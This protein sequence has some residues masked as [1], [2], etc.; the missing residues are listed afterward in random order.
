MYTIKQAAARTGIPIPLLRAWQSRY[1]IVSPTRTAAGY[2]LYDDAALDRLRSMR[3]LVDEGWAPSTAARAI[4]AGEAPVIP[5]PAADG[6][7]TG[8]DR[9]APDDGA[10]GRIDAFIAASIAL[11]SVRLEH[12]LDEMFAR[13]SF[14]QVATDEV[15]PALTAIGEAWAAGRLGVGGE[16]AASHAVLR[17][18]A[19]AFQAAGR[20]SG[21]RGAV[22]VGLPSGSRHELGAL[23]FAVAARRAG[24]P[25]LYLGPD[26]PAADWVATAADTHARAAVIGSLTEADAAAAAD[27][28]RALRAE[29][30]AVLIGFGGRAADLAAARFAEGAPR[31]EPAIALSDILTEAVDAVAAR[32]GAVTPA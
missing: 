12:V 14:E 6:S 21:S 20:P 17:R 7:A 19:A 28:G 24:L 16:H 8:V 30:P 23:A 25:V 1:G 11:D 31:A 22:L 4:L 10:A 3:A 32:L 5:A 13:G 26:L 18:L 29:D 27:V 9:P 15:L 2:R